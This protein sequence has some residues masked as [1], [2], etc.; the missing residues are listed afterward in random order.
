MTVSRDTANAPEQ[1]SAC[2][3]CDFLRDSPTS[4]C[5][6]CGYEPS[7]P[8]CAVVTVRADPAEPLRISP[9]GAPLIEADDDRDL[10]DHD[11][12][13]DSEVG[14]LAIGSGWIAR[15][16]GSAFGFALFALVLLMGIAGVWG[17][18]DTIN[19]GIARLIAM[20]LS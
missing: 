2:P 14:D 1:L 4:C 19:R 12:D 16:L 15:S 11:R 18:P 7:C 20:V 9:W 17:N 6:S 3:R 5:D 10:G 13:R 8:C